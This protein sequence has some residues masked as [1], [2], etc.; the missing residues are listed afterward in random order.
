MGA[1]SVARH[2]SVSVCIKLVVCLGNLRVDNV[3][4]IVFN[5]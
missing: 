5:T 2:F 4:I 3:V 1:V